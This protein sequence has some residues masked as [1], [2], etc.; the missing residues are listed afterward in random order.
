MVLRRTEMF[1]FVAVGHYVRSPQIRLANWISFG[2]MVTRL[3]MDGTQ[4]GIIEQ[5]NKVSL[6]CLLETQYCRRLEPQV[7]LVVLGDLPHQP[8]ERQLSDEQRC[9]FLE[10]T[11]VIQSCR[12]HSVP[13]GF[14]QPPLHPRLVDRSQL[15]W[16]PIQHTRAQYGS[17]LLARDIKDSQVSI[18]RGVSCAHFM[19]FFTG[20]GQ[21]WWSTFTPC[22][23]ALVRVIIVVPALLSALTRII[24][25][26]PA[27]AT[28]A[29]T[30]T[31]TATCAGTAAGRWLLAW[32]APTRAV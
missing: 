23:P 29:G 26:G 3:G 22:L 1:V 31:T 32:S 18:Y 10:V 8:L 15:F 14:H 12:P 11:D 24:T 20:Q 4:V 16:S 2:M 6:C 21:F 17:L 9:V 25:S 27:Y 5:P 28:C 19:W 13:V 30:I 7:C